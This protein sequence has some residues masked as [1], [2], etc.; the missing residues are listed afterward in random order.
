MNI[1]KYLSV[2]RLFLAITVACFI[3]SAKGANADA[4][5]NEDL[6]GDYGFSLSGTSLDPFGNRLPISGVGQL[7]VVNGVSLQHTRTFN[8]GSF[9]IVDGVLV[10]RADVRAD[11]RGVVVFCGDNT[12]RPPDILPLFPRKS[13]EIFE[14]VL[15]GKNADEILFIGTGFD[16]LPDNFD[17]ADCPSPSE[18]MPGTAAIGGVIVGT[19][20]R[21]HDGDD[22]D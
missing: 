2:S 7:T 5:S 10:G 4:F 21:Q 8:I 11:G 6:T 15:T 17:L 16:A 18:I 22:D 9:G 19:A 14:I 20:R 3:F 12:V 13:L 1:P